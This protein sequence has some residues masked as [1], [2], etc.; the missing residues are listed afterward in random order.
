MDNL[1]TTMKRTSAVLILIL[2][3]TFSSCKGQ[4]TKTPLKIS[5]FKFES[6]FGTTTKEPKN[7]YCL[8]GTRFFRAP[9]SNNSDSL[10]AE[11]INAHPNASVIQVSSLGQIET[12]DPE[13]TITYC[14]VVDIKD[15]LNNYLIR[16]GCYP[17]GT[18]MRPKTWKEIEKGEKEL[19]KDRD[20]KPDVKVFVDK[21]AYDNFIEQIKIAEQFA[22]ENKLGIWLKETAE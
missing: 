5:D 3:L 10:I 20:A 4:Q 11:W 16:N 22:R 18:M 9:S 21:K 15:T 14:W 13:T 17:G 2:S 12:K 7:T 6:I 19:Y 1:K 8:L